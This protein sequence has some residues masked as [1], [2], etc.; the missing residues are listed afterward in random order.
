MPDA[1]HDNCFE[2]YLV[3][4]KV[5]QPAE[6]KFAGSGFPPETTPVRKT[7]QRSLSQISCT[8]D[9]R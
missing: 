8:V 3:N 9:W 7:L 6:Y 5:R 2:L 1:K 4:D